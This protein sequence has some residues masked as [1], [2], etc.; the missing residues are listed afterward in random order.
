MSKSKNVLAFEAALKENEELREKF[1]A[2]QQRI[3]EEN[4]D[5]GDGEILVRSAAEV[6]FTL[7]MEELERAMAQSQELDDD[8]LERVSGGVG[9]FD[10]DWC[11][12]EYLCNA[13]YNN[14]N[15]NGSRTRVCLKGYTPPS[16]AT[17]L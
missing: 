4:E 12:V 6:G 10:R 2:A 8:E 5:V 11:W 3:A 14:R 13:F 7:T 16:T 17:K 1:V 9:I 15:K